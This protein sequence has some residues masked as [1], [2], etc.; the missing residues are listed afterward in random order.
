MKSFT[1][2]KT[3][4]LTSLL[5]VVAFGA[6]STLETNASARPHLGVQ[7][8]ANFETASTPS[9]ISSRTHTGYSVGVVADFP[10]AG[11]FSI[12]PELNYTRRGIE[13]ANIGGASA[14]VNYHSIELPV[15]AKVAFLDGIRPYVFA[16]PMGVW[17]V[18]T[19]LTGSFSGATGSSSFN[20]KTFDIAAV[21]GVGIEIG[22][23]FAN[24]RYVLG[25]TDINS[26][27]AEWKSR[28]FKLLAGLKF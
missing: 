2:G 27:S 4:V 1:F 25:L 14:G 10:V 16:G 17:N 21:A 15:L 6:E 22:S 13:L 28:G 7:V 23:L 24:A 3:V 9:A 8:G 19:E 12:Q 18:S 20:P 26:N 11:V 5:S